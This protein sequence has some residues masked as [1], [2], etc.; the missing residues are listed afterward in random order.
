M[1]CGKK[2]LFLLIVVGAVLLTQGKGSIITTDEK[3]NLRH[4]RAL[5]SKRGAECSVCKHVANFAFKKIV[6]H[7]CGIV[8]KLEGAAMCEAV[9]FGPED[10]A[11]DICVAVVWKGCGYIANKIY[12]GFSSA[13]HLCSHWCAPEMDEMDYGYDNMYDSAPHLGDGPNLGGGGGYNPAPH[14]GDGPNLGG[15]GGYNPAPHLDMSSPRWDE[16]DNDD[17]LGI[18]S[19]FRGGRRAY[20]VGGRQAV[21][22]TKYYNGGTCSGRSIESRISKYPIFSGCRKNPWSSSGYVRGVTCNGRDSFS[23]YGCSDSACRHCTKNTWSTEQCHSFRNRF[24]RFNSVSHN[25]EC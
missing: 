15:G 21:M 11:A 22:T 16:D 19:Y 17:G 6:K 2:T 12:Q 13:E 10:P 4:H 8:T 24:N 5:W 23:F 1:K 18:G 14:L 20:G 25:V 3:L 7:G 9:G